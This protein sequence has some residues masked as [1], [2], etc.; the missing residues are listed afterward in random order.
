MNL[1]E[2]EHLSIF[3]F[4]RNAKKEKNKD[5]LFIIQ[6]KFIQQDGY[7]LKVNYTNP[8]DLTRKRIFEFCFVLFH[9]LN[10]EPRGNKE[11]AFLAPLR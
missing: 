5:K 9:I 1:N 8:L 10:Y 6:Q 2:P 7:T 11:V 4:F 3:G